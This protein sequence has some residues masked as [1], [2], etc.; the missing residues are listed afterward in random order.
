M[1]NLS[2][3]LLEQ[4]IIIETLFCNHLLHSN[5]FLTTLK[6]IKKNVAHLEK[7]ATNLVWEQHEYQKTNWGSQARFRHK[8]NTTTR[9][10]IQWQPE[11]GP[12]QYV[13]CSYCIFYMCI[14]ERCCGETASVLHGVMN[15]VNADFDYLDRHKR[16]R[17]PCRISEKAKTEK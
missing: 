15:N 9:W 11:F 6:Q 13:Q 10:A 12:R 1:L 16:A 14:F 4:I 8:V 7:Q 17:T 3:W 5:P 2:L